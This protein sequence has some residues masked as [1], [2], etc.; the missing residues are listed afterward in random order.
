MASLEIQIL[1]ALCTA[2]RGEG[3]PT[4]FRA[5]RGVYTD[6]RAED[7][8]HGVAVVRAAGQ[9][10]E[11][12]ANPRGPLNLHRLQVTV[13]IYALAGRVSDPEDTAREIDQP[14]EDVTDP[15]VTWARRAIMADPRL[16]GLANNVQE[17]GIAWEDD[18]EDAPLAAAVLILE[19]EYHNRVTNPEVRS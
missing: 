10:T 17:T 14:P 2:L 3:R 5:M 8:E 12:A 4:G 16:G 18:F 15:Y 9:E 11:R 7:V 19:V 1:D 13:A 6:L